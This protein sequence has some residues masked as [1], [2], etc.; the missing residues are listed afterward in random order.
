VVREAWLRVFKTKW[1]ARFARRNGIADASLAEAV[2]RAERSLVDADLGGGV[3]KQRVARPGQG[4]S[5][6]Y[7]MLAAYRHGARAVFLFGF[8][9]SERDDI[10]PDE[11]ATL[12]DV[13]K[14][15]LEA[16]S[17]ALAHAVEDGLI[18]EIEYGKEEA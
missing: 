8:A 5:G 9:K 16:D 7:R 2:R 12:R 3:I 17:R 14:G 4:R 18:Q 15:W 1:L 6:G 11:S 13:A 10:E